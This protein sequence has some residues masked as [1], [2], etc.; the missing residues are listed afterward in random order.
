M[1]H[2][3]GGDFI[4]LQNADA[5]PAWRACVR[6]HFSLAR[7]RW[8]SSVRLLVGPAKQADAEP[9]RVMINST[10]ITERRRISQGLDIGRVERLPESGEL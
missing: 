3:G 8:Q 7:W 5:T 4:A 6:E 9:V 1:P 10:A 2:L